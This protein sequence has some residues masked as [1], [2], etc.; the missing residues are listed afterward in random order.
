VSTLSP[1]ELALM[2]EYRLAR[3]LWEDLTAELPATGAGRQNALA[4]QAVVDI[5]KARLGEPGADDPLCCQRYGRVHDLSFAVQGCR[6][7]GWADRFATWDL[8]TPDERLVLGAIGAEQG[9]ADPK[10]VASRL[11]PMTWQRVTRHVRYLKGLALASIRQLP[12]MTIYELTGAGESTLAAGLVG[13]AA[14]RR[15]A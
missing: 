9:V 4:A 15:T 3:R 8:L 5:L 6:W 11:R 7:H 10:S 13:E 14:A 2:A 1:R 12:K